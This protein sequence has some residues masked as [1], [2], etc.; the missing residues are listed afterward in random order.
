MQTFWTTFFPI[1]KYHSS[2]FFLII[3]SIS[4]RFS[5]HNF[6]SRIISQKRKQSKNLI[7]REKR[8]EKKWLW[9]NRTKWSFGWLGVLV[10]SNLRMVYFGLCKAIKMRCFRREIDLLTAKKHRDKNKETERGTNK[11]ELKWT[12]NWKSLGILICELVK[13][14]SLWKESQL[15]TACGATFW[16]TRAGFRTHQNRHT[17]WIHKGLCYMVTNQRQIV[18]VPHLSLRHVRTV[19]TTEDDWNY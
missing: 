15:D 12:L 11:K 13:T 19:V 16:G 4:T 2:F 3:N 6:E 8:R 9:A 17:H 7:L 5:K 18:T 10:Y 14:G 1:H